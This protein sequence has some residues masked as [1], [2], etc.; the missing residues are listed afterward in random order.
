MLDELVT[1]PQFTIP[2]E[3]KEPLLLERMTR[4]VEHHRAACP[5]YA[6]VLDA[7]SSGPA[8]SLADLPYLPVSLFKSHLLASVPES[9]RFKTMTSSGTTGQ[10]VSRIVL[11]RA[12]ADAQ[13][14]ALAAVMRAALGP[15]RLPMLVIDTPGVVRDRATFSARGAGVLGMMSFGR[16]HTYVLDDDMQLDVP[17]LL[18]FCERFRDTPVLIFGFTYMVWKYFHRRIVE[19]GLDVAL[20]NAVLVHSGGWKKLQEEAV[21]NAEFRAA[22]HAS[23]GIG[24]VRNFYGMVEQVGGVFLEGDDGFL[25]PPNFSEVIVRDPVTWE[26]APHGTVGVVEVLSTL[27][28]SYPGHVLLTEDLGIV[29]GVADPA[30]GWAGKQLEIVG[31]VPRT[32]LRGCSDT[33]AYASAS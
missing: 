29:H 23:A 15:R 26:E 9:E 22:L 21:G 11:D 4:L 12:T 6:R 8:R 32:E 18:Q 14:R 5:G 7:L 19:L 24:R 2:Q 20:P 30:S 33:H 27:P 3:Q 25:H 13:A 17:A 16:A 28:R 10:Q 1:R 31:R